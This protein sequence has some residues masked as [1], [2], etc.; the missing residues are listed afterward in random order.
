MRIVIDNTGVEVYDTENTP[1]KTEVLSGIMSAYLLLQDD[2][3]KTHPIECMDC[4]AYQ[5][6]VRMRKFLIDEAKKANE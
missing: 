6:Q 4:P 3:I 1:N 2:F 5:Q